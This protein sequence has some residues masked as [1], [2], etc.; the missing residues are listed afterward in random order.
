MSDPTRWRVRYA[1][2]LPGVS[3]TCYAETTLDAATIDEAYTAAAE[4]FDDEVTPLH[5]GTTPHLTGIVTT[6]ITP[7]RD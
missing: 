4:I 7:E 1:Y 6:P 5:H 2:T 3:E